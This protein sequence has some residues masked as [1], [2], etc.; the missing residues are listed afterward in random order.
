MSTQTKTQN[1]TQIDWHN[2]PAGARW[3]SMGRDGK[4]C[5]HIMAVC[6]ESIEFISAITWPAPTFGYT[7][8]WRE[9]LRERPA[10][11]MASNAYC[12]LRSAGCTQAAHF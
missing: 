9:S 4:A 10:N 12:L 8:D 1:D 7:A 5:W 6:A 11:E 2:A 3:W